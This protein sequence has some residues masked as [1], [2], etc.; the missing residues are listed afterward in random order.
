MDLHEAADRNV[1]A[2][3]RHFA[4]HAA[5]AT[6]VEKA[7][8]LLV[9][10]ATPFT[11]AFH[12]AAVRLDPGADPDSTIEEV[13]SFSEQQGR[14]IILW[15]STERDD[16]LIEAAV[17]SGLR[18]RSATVGMA[19]YEPPGLPVVSDSV[20]L[21]RVADSTGVAGF[22]AVHESLLGDASVVAHFASSGAL[23][24]P[25]AA[26]F[27][28]RVEGRP[29]ACA[30]AVMSGSGAGVYWV[31]TCTDFRRRGYG[32]LAT[33][34]AVRAA[35]ESGARVVTLQSTELGL[36]VYR[37]LG[38]VPFTSYARYLAQV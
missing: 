30:M 25:E 6:I 35:F 10:A 9:A 5:G 3:L 14:D 1:A 2:A 21:V 22:G 13:R 34:A 17:A 32:E 31:A 23:L 33:R 18:L 12:N 36:P 4:A 38:F 28:V 19:T 11:G 29:V 26:A 15:A 24:A 8:V 20:E 37:R 27:V 16:D 7:A